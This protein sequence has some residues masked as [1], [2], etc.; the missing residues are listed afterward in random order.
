[1]LNISR[2]LCITLAVSILPHALSES[3]NFTSRQAYES[4]KAK[5]LFVSDSARKITLDP[6]PIMTFDIKKL[7]EKTKVKVHNPKYFGAIQQTRISYFYMEAGK[8]VGV[9]IEI[10]SYATTDTARKAT[11]YF[12]CVGKNPCDS[13]KYSFLKTKSNLVAN[14]TFI[15]NKPS[16]KELIKSKSLFDQI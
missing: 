16:D 3:R 14:F 8:E 10:I 5:K 4:F 2:I 13:I 7:F 6:E 11:K 9:D 15:V 12:D 1:M